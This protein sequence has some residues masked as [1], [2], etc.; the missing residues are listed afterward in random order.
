MKT[1]VNKE[2]Y[3]IY[4]DI[5]V[6]LHVAIRKEIVPDIEAIFSKFSKVEL[7]PDNYETTGIYLQNGGENEYNMV[8]EN[9]VETKIKI[10]N[11]RFNN[12]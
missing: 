2:K 1:N 4:N 5:E 11:L 10:K 9:E 8:I 6:G 7:V 12:L 3:Q